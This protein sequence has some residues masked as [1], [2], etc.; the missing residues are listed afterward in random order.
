MSWFKSLALAG[1]LTATNISQAA[2]QYFSNPWVDIKV[3]TDKHTIAHTNNYPRQSIVVQGEIADGKQLGKATI[4]VTA[5]RPDAYLEVGVGNKTIEGKTY[6]GIDQLVIKESA[7]NTET[8]ITKVDAWPWPNNTISSENLNHLWIKNNSHSPGKIFL[9][10]LSAYSSK[11]ETID[12]PIAPAYVPTTWYGNDPLNLWMSQN[13][14]HCREARYA[15]LTDI[16]NTHTNAERMFVDILPEKLMIEVRGN[17]GTLTPETLDWCGLTEEYLGEP[18]PR[19]V[20][21]NSDGTETT[22]YGRRL[23]SGNIA[24]KGRDYFWYPDKN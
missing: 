7:K 5:K 1:L 20:R 22:R 6:G 4:E 8:I 24:L 23:P 21:K 19:K 15:K 18:F 12:V 10:D 17:P 14:D 9:W 11:I 3:T 13:S 16:E 2:T